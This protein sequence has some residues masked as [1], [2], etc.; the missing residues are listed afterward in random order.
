MLFPRLFLTLALAAIASAQAPRIFYSDLDSGPK[1]GGENNMGAYVSV[2]G[3]NF[4]S[5]RGSS[6]V[7]IGGGSAA[8]YPIWTNNKITFQLGPVAAS[9]EIRVAT[10]SGT[11][12]GVSFSVRSGSIYFVSTGGS[13]AAAGGFSSPWRTIQKGVNTMAAGDTVYVMNGVVEARPGSSDGSV[14]LYYNNGAP[15]QPKAI[16]GYPGAVAAIGSLGSGPCGTTSCTE[17][18]KATYPSSYWTIA[19]L[20]LLGNN[21]GIA[22]K[23]T[24]YRVVGN[25]FTCPQ[26]T[27]PTACLEG[28]QSLRVK[29]YGNNVHDVGFAGSSGLYHG[30]YFSTDTSYLDIGWNSVTNIKGC[31]GIQIHSS[32]ADSSSGFNQF[33]IDIHD[34]FIRDTQCDGIVLATIDPSKGAVRVFNNVIVNGGRGP[35]TPELGGHYAC[36]YVAGTTNNGP[37]G[38]GIVDIYNNTLVN[39]GGSAPFGNGGVAFARRSTTMDV[40]LRNN[41]FYHANSTPYILAYDGPA[42]ISGSNNL[43]YGNGPA[44]VDLPGLGSSFSG[45]PRFASATS[46]FHILAGSAARG[47]GVDAGLV[48]DIEGTLR[49]APS[50]IGAYAGTGASSVTSRVTPSRSREWMWSA[51]TAVAGRTPADRPSNCS[52]CF[53]MSAARPA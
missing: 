10:G 21:Y 53:S 37:E 29:V 41:I 30:I 36:V 35:I 38:S 45:D 46:D 49:G 51:F 52:A 34:N 40:R 8:N 43:F 11:S 18:L 22:V 31:R 28:T 9:G 19:N 1:T 39:C 20:R 17:G 33:A 25:E 15:G 12:N 48:T 32:R 44:P 4:G 7:T 5:S 2:Y 14:T 13:D 42:T 47:T 16:I 24:D 27:G 50:D 26:G 3:A 23:G 6:T